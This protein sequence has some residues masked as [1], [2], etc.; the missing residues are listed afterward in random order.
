L[1]RVALVAVDAAA[2]VVGAALTVVPVDAV[3]AA[4]DLSVLE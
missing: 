3:A 2:V 4:L 1:V